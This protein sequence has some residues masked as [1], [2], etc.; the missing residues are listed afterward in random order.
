MQVESG[1][2]AEVAADVVA[3][4]PAPEV[5]AEAA[6]VEATAEGAEEAPEAE[7][8]AP[9]APVEKVE[10]KRDAVS[11]KFAALARREKE[12]Q[13]QNQQAKRYEQQI[14]QRQAE[15]EAKAKDLAAREAKIKSGNPIEVL[16]A[17]GYTYA[18]A[19][20]AILGG[21]KPKEVDPIDQKLAPIEER[22]S[23]ITQENEELKKRL[24]ELDNTA[25]AKKQREEYEKFVDAV[26][27]TVKEAGDKYEYLNTMGSDGIDIVRE[28]MVQYWQA[29]E[30]ALLSY[31]DACDLVE[32]HF[33][34]QAE[35][36][37]STKK[38]QAKLKPAVESK[39]QTPSKPA[40]VSKT[41]TS[42]MTSGGEATVD[43]NKMSRSEAIEHL[44]K[45][46][47]F[48]GD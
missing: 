5:A 41:L 18:D 36:L 22:V 46:I 45:S 1:S 42:G 11:G 32:E 13:Q 10:P 39:P 33:E 7:V 31:E 26:K 23:K 12:L 43:I 21:F 30:G 25:A 44:A 37:L 4:A 35:V 40:V 15:I 24:A 47:S 9:E 16:M 17:S 6:P 27:K 2:A 29:N 8:A 34:K 48:R 20:N 14:A 3:S 28:T 19:T 38:V